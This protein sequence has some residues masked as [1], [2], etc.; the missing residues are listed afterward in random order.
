MCLWGVFPEEICTWIGKLMMAD[1]PPQSG[2]APSNPMRASVEQKC[3]R[4]N[5][6]HEPSHPSPALRTLDISAPGPLAMGLRL[7]I[8]SPTTELLHQLTS[9]S[10]LQTT[11]LTT[12][13]MWASFCNKSLMC[14]LYI[15]LCFVSLEKLAN[16]LVHRKATDS[17]LLVFIS[18]LAK[19]FIISNNLSTNYRGFSL[20]TTIGAVN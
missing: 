19:A 4:T 2:W 8:T 5:S 11:D 7:T 6:L 15:L 14:I 17:C 1:G 13:T 20:M 9:F 12:L 16:T 18:H 10:S 3:R